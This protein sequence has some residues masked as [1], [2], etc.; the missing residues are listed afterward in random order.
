MSHLQNPTN[1]ITGSGSI[2]SFELR[3]VGVWHGLACMDQASPSSLSRGGAIHSSNAGVTIRS[4]QRTAAAGAPFPG[5]CSSPPL[6]L[7]IKGL[8]DGGGA[9]IS[10]IRTERVRQSSHCYYPSVFMMIIDDLRRRRHHQ[11]MNETLSPIST[12]EL[13]EPVIRRLRMRA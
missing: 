12:E 2:S 6:P 7:P 5:L 13:L 8:L 1:L 4:T 10:Q 3:V 9:H 11:Q